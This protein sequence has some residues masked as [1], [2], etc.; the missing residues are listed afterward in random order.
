VNLTPPPSNSI[1]LPP[2]DTT[3]SESPWL[4]SSTL[5]SSFP[6]AH[7]GLNGKTAISNPH[8]SHRKQTPQL[9][10]FPRCVGFECK[11]RA[12]RPSQRKQQSTKAA[13]SKGQ[14]QAACQAMARCLTQPAGRCRFIQRTKERKSMRNCG[15]RLV[16]SI[17]RNVLPA[18]QGP[19]IRLHRLFQPGHSQTRNAA[20]GHE[21][22]LKTGVAQGQGLC[23]QQNQRSNRGGIQQLQPAKRKIRLTRRSPS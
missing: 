10:T 22:E 5:T 17:P 13:D 20:D 12:Q 1:V 15:A 4:T 14:R 9:K 8:T 18:S 21:W 2:G 11:P 7:S 19:H 3:N 23:N 16:R 6:L